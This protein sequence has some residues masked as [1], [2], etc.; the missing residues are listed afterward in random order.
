MKLR[1][2]VLLLL[3]LPLVTLADELVGKV[4]HVSDGDSMI[5]QVNETKLR[6]RMHGIDAPERTQPYNRKARQSLVEL[7][8]DRTVTVQYDKEDKYGRIV[9]K[10]LVNGT[11]AGLV[12]LQRGMAWFYRFYQDELAPEDRAAYA[13]AE[14]AARRERRGLWAGSDP[15]PPWEFR[16]KRQ[17]GK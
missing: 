4:V 16:R 15:V 1:S 9:G 14:A 3:L 17:S 7:V 6:V 13:Q 5:V 11:D 12:Q 10:V 2:F 8:A